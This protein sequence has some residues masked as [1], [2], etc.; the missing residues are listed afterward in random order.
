MTAKKSKLPLWYPDEPPIYDIHKTYMDNLKHG[1]FFKGEIP[2]RKMPP[3]AKWHDFLGHKIASP[4]GVPA[5]PLL[6]ANWIELASLLGFDVLTYKTIRSDEHPAHPLPNMIFVNTKENAPEA[7]ET[8]YPDPDISKLSVTNSFGMP[9]KDPEFLFEDI[10]KANACL[11][12]GQVMIVS[13]AGTNRAGEDYFEDFLRAALFAKEAGA[14]IVEAN[15]SCP[16]VHRSE[17]SIY[18]NPETVYTLGKKLASALHPTPLVIKVGAFPNALLLK[19]VLQHAAKAG[20]AA[21]CG[22]NT[23]S[24]K[25]VDTSGNPALG[26]KRA[27]GG[28]CGGVIRNIALD[29]VENASKINAE[30]KLGLCIMGVGGITLPEHF[31]L[32]IKRGA[33]VAL[34]ATGMMWDPYLAM[35]YHE[36]HTC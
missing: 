33:S 16:N 26:E 19:E 24:K 18:L 10:A 14:K 23:L 21:V 6:S 12:P 17:G 4:L 11:K 32:F 35:R 1:P 30:E 31:D 29:F 3:K 5:G 36:E 8:K 27:V 20:I 25:I 13:I 15:F 7:T 34:T 22:I 2:Q 9:S 28:I